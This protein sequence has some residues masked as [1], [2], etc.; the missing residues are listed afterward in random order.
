MK[1]YAGFILYKP[2]LFFLWLFAKLKI[3]RYF[4]H[5]FLYFFNNAALEI[6]TPYD[7]SQGMFELT[8]GSRGIH[9]KLITFFIEYGISGAIPFVKQPSN[10]DFIPVFKWGMSINL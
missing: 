5:D 2:A 7:F 8:I 10:V 1:K 3:N 6:L 4:D 9:Y